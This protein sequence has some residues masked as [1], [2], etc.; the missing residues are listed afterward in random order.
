VTFL[1]ECYFATFFVAFKMLE[2]SR[3]AFLALDALK[4]VVSENN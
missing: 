2:V 1:A 3:K 4:I